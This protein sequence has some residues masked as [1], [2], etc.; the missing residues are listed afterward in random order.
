MPAAVAQAHAALFDPAQLAIG[1]HH[2]VLHAVI[3]P[4][5]HLTLNI[6]PGE[7]K[8]VGR[9]DRCPG[10]HRIPGKISWVKSRQIAATLADKRHGPIRVRRALERH[11]R[12][13]VHHR[14]QAAF[15]VTHLRAARG[16]LRHVQCHAQGARHG[17][18]IVQQRHAMRVVLARLTRRIKNDQRAA[19]RAARRNDFHV[20]RLELL[21]HLQRKQVEVRR[22]DDVDLRAIQLELAHTPE[23]RI[24]R[25]VAVGGILNPCRLGHAVEKTAG[26]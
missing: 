6:V 23:R 15:V 12:Q 26:E 10:A 5:G 13:V 9:D 25:Y 18:R 3:Q 22:I 16:T 7:H 11:R 14:S 20:F 1:R 2:A 24:D 21:C 4:L 8:I 19:F 17:P